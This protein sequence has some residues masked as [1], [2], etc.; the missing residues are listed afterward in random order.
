VPSTTRTRTLKEAGNYFNHN[1]VYQKGRR[2]DPSE[3]TDAQLLQTW[4]D[5]NNEWR[6][7]AATGANPGAVMASVPTVYRG[8]SSLQARPGV[9]VKVDSSGMVQPG[10]GISVNADPAGLEKFGG[11]RQVE[12]IPPELE[13]VQRGQNPNHFEI[14]PRNR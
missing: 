6:A 11:A 7:I 10:K 4:R 14:A 8:G 9:D 12:S 5:F 2:V 3:M 13:I 1:D